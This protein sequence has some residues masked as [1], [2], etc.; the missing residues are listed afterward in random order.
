MC[1]ISP[2]PGLRVAAASPALF[3]EKIYL[4]SELADGAEDSS[5]QHIIGNL[6]SWVIGLPGPRLRGRVRNARC[7][8]KTWAPRPESRKRVFS[9]FQGLS[10]NTL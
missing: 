2:G 7:K 4:S 8:L 1:S 10:L 6:E 9:F 5:N 3:L